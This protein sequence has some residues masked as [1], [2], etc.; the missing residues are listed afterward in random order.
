[1]KIAVIGAGAMGSLF[2]AYLTQAGESVTVVDIWPE[3]IRAI[4]KQGLILESANGEQ[5]FPLVATTEIHQLESVDLVILFVK[6]AATRAA[7]LSAATIL[8]Q[9]GRILTL[10]NGLGNAETIADVIGRE[11]VL[12]GTT[13]QGATML[14]PGRVRHAGQGDTHIG[15][16]QGGVD[17]FCQD[18]AAILSRSGLPAFVETDVRGLVWGK[19]VVNTGINA[20]T[21]LLR[22]RNGQLVELPETKK[23]LEMAVAEAVQVAKAAGIQLPYSDPVEKVV[24]V[25]I[26]TKNN[27]SSM[28]QDILRGSPT[29][30][31]VINGAIVREGERLGVATPV[32]QTL[33]LLVRSLEKNLSTC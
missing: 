12:V 32:N 8:R 33:T 18:V 6:S 11:R 26:A 2:G 1:M 13:A 22:L 28:L 5:M 9:D 4:Q 15:K 30:I 16:M 14:G 21:A 17:Q 10:Q 24:S 27:Q 20:L 3:H 25:A 29:E 23:L 19:L 7:A 31:A